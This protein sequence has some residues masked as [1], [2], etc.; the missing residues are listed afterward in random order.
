MAKP[1]IPRIIDSPPPPPARTS[2]GRNQTGPRNS[3]RRPPVIT[4]RRAEPPH[5]RSGPISSVRDPPFK[6]LARGSQPPRR[7]LPRARESGAILTLACAS[8]PFIRRSAAVGNPASVRLTCSLSRFVRY[9]P[10]GQRRS[11]RRPARGGHYGT[12]SAM[13]PPT[14]PAGS[15]AR[16][17]ALRASGREAAG[18]ARQQPFALTPRGS[19]PTSAHNRLAWPARAL[20]SAAPFD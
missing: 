4:S 14:G 6:A 17:L 7:A 9:R 18:H 1:A 15:P 5:L 11:L 20:R 2:K 3:T 8:P 16:I 10:S 12:A 13:G 19:A